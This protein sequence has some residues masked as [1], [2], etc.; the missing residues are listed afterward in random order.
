MKLTV[1]QLREV[2]RLSEDAFRH[3]KQVLP[4]MSGRNGY[5]P[6]FTFGDLL[7]LAV[8]KELC[9]GS[10]VQVGALRPVV[11]AL[12]AACNNS[13]WPKL[14]SCLFVIR[15]ERQELVTASELQSPRFEDV[16]LVVPCRPIIIKLRDR[17]LAEH[18]PGV[19]GL[20]MFPP[21]AVSRRGRARSVGRK[22]S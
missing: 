4:P 2:L 20:L 22:R 3:W 12:F 9:D 17:L 19:Q 21:T 15:L 11:N 5:R 8:V 10:G 1:G 14:E 16:T 7:A 18:Q 6:C 13:P